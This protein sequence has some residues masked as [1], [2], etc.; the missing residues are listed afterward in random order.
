MTANPHKLHILL[1]DDEPAFKV[2]TSMVLTHNGY[3]VSQACD[4]WEALHL[5]EEIY[6]RGDQL[7][8]L[9]TD[10]NME[11]MSGLEL[12]QHVRALG[13]DV[14]VLVASGFIYDEGFAQLQQIAGHKFLVKPFRAEVMLAYVKD[15]IEQK[16]N[17]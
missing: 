10:L 8:L 6:G 3:R 11:L 1:V 2:F 13:I 7:D 12:I 15:L 17:P 5:I 4:G 14:P 9:F 16:V